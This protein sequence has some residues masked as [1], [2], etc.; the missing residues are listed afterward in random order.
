[1]AERRPPGRD[2][3]LAG[4][5]AATA[6]VVAM[7]V[8][9][10]RATAVAV[11]RAFDTILALVDGMGRP[12][13]ATP[14]MPIVVV[15]IDA[16]ALD[17]VGPWPWRRRVIAD[18]VETA[19]AAGA[20]AV[21]IDIVF[22]QPDERSPAALARRLA[23]TTG[24]D[25]LA[26]LARGLE[27]DDP[28]LAA[29]FARVPVVLGFALAP[30]AGPAPAGP[31]LLIHGDPGGARLWRAPGAEGPT[32]VLAEPAAALAADVLSG[33]ADGMVRRVPLVV[34]VAGE[35]R[36]GLALEAVRVALGADHLEL[37]H[38]QRRFV[39]GSISGALGDDGMLRLVPPTPSRR[40]TIV[41]AADLLAG[42]GSAAIP[43]GALVFLGGSAPEL[44]GLRAAA[45]RP[46]A[47]S[48]ELHAAAARQILEG[49]T[50][51]RPGGAALSAAAAALV[52]APAIAAG[53]WIAPIL[54]SVVTAGGVF[55]FLA[56]VL[57]AAGAGLLIDP[58]TPLVA[59]LAGHGGAALV[60]FARQRRD[61]GRIR[62]RF[63][64]HLA[65]QVVDLIVRDPSLLRLAG[66][67]RVVTAL[68]TDVAEFTAMTRRAEPE[69][70]VAVLDAYFEG[71]T[72]I[73]VAHGGMIDKFVGDAVH[74][75][76]NAPLD[77][78][79]HAV[80]AVDCAVELVRW[81]EA[82]RRE[83]GPAALG[84]GLTRV[85]IETGA[86]IVGEIG[87][88]SK[89]DYTA[90]GDAVNA[91]ARLEAAN[92][93]L[94]TRICIGPGTAALCP[95]GRLRRSGTVDLRGIAG[96]VP[97]W[98]PVEAAEHGEGPPVPLEGPG[99][100]TGGDPG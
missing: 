31:A 45:G 89:L 72:R 78:P 80:A 30:T 91:A 40:P 56:A 48:V 47:A 3:A 58:V 75:F 59:A 60:A 52:A 62:R 96:E 94:G 1:M 92:K 63:E 4:I 38:G 35:E 50:P 8:A 88:G 84:F 22:S 74:A 10:P 13:A 32:T 97:T 55:A 33:D 64:Q 61:A 49:R 85:G 90:H 16:D 23:A 100:I 19:A 93:I 5:L 42:A 99:R 28:R 98:E 67:R 41:S 39:V 76:F 83:P 68:F 54:G 24:R 69:A 34:E 53:A 95:P 46:L 65:P 86:A 12:A 9:M 26:A 73:V 37:D 71:M 81:S 27:D 14:P 25:D 43:K 79:D 44:G 21:A 6:V 17:L 51:H 18:L 29:A 20:A 11:E 82:M 7:L 2:A 70:L 66:E 36:P 87:L 77:R 15:D 57:A